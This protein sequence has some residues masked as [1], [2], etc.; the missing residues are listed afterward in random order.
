MGQM[1]GTIGTGAGLA[2]IPHDVTRGHYKRSDQGP[3]TMPDGCS[4]H[5]DSS[6]WK[7]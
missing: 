6:T 4:S 5:T 1:G 7:I 3:D 2:H